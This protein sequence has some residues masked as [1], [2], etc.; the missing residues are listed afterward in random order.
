MSV[1]IFDYNEVEGIRNAL[2]EIKELESV[3]LD[4]SY[5][6]QFNSRQSPY[7][8]SSEEAL[9]RLLWYM[10]VA[11]RIAGSLQYQEN[12]DIFTKEVPA[13]KYSMEDAVS[14]FGS[15][16]YNIFTNDGNYFLSSEWFGLCEDV[17]KFLKEKFPQYA[18]GGEVENESAIYEWNTMDR[19]HRLDFLNEIEEDVNI[20]EDRF[21]MKTYMYDDLP[22]KVRR[23]VQ[24]RLSY[25]KGGEVF[26]AD[27]EVQYS[28]GG[29]NKSRDDK[30]ISKEPHEQ[31]YAKKRK[32][33][34]TYRRKK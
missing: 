1:L 34:K 16:R 22:P 29:R 19:F 6:I 33:K 5:I 2:T 7:K 12:V 18:K 8:Y 30:F 31:S 25:A 28:R 13:L 32:K 20:G 3:V 26:D 11:N 10:Y 23:E 15:L 17:Y 21:A 4:N 14:R 27:T 24:N 9:G